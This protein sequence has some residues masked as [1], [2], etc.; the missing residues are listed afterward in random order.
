MNFKGEYN[1]LRE[2]VEFFFWYIRTALMD[3]SV[4]NVSL[5]YMCCVNYPNKE[6]NLL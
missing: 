6:I 4:L 5:N 3:K 1:I 2:S